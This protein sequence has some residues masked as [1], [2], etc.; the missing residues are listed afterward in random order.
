[1]IGIS[2]AQRVFR[3]VMNHCKIYSYQRRTAWFGF[4]EWL[5]GNQR[6]KTVGCFK[7]FFVQCG[8][9]LKSNIFLSRIKRTWHFAW[10]ASLG[11]YD[12]PKLVDPIVINKIREIK[13]WKSLSQILTFLDKFFEINF[14]F[15]T[16]FNAC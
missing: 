7:M 6:K 2:V 15:L 5:Q 3:D 1:M 4:P 14:C 9:V 8:Y 10:S 12:L 16:N 11:A 13:P